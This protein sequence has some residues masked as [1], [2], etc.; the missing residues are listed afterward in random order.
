[1]A[2]RVDM[3][4]ILDVHN[5]ARYPFNGNLITDYAITVLGDFWSKMITSD[6]LFKSN[7]LVLI[8]LMN[9]KSYTNELLNSF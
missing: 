3:T 2:Y 8:G 1:M 5:Y 4:V 7:P 6:P 9:G